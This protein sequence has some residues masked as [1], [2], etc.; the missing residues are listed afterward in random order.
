MV[1]SP[2]DAVKVGPVLS[3]RPVVQ[4]LVDTAQSMIDLGLVEPRGGRR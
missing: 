2:L 3:Y 4:T 1:R